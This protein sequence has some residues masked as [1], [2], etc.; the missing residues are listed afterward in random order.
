MC[1][2]PHPHLQVACE[3]LSEY[4]TSTLSP[5]IAN[6][7]AAT[8]LCSKFLC[9]GKGRCVRK[10]YDSSQYLHLNP[11]DF[12]ILRAKTKYVAI[13]LPSTA[14]LDDWAGNF[15][16]QCYAGGSCSPKLSQP[17]EIQVIWV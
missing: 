6:V 2:P 17:T 13:G 9:Q 10:D 7:T 5:Y 4:L 1:K 3:S 8:M 11:I 16:C 12:R 14:D 15:T